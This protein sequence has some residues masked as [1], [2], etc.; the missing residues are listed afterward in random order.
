MSKVASVTPIGQS[1]CVNGID[2]VTLAASCYR[3]VGQ[4]VSSFR[5]DL[6][7]VDAEDLSSLMLLIEKELEAGIGL[8]S[9]EQL[10]E[11]KVANE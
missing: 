5:G 6:S 2:Q 11:R 3:A 4:L 10:A 9:V 7:L 1:L 8:L